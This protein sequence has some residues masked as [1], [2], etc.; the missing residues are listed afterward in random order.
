MHAHVI[1]TERDLDSA[2]S[3]NSNAIVRSRRQCLR[4]G[5]TYWDNLIFEFGPQ[6]FIYADGNAVVGFASERDAA[7]Q[8][9]IEFADKYKT[10]PKPMGGCFQL[11]K[12]QDDRIDTAA[13][14]LEPNTIV[15]DETLKL[16]YG[17]GFAEWHH[18]YAGQL[19]ERACGLSILQGGPGTGK[20]SYLRHL[21]GVL[22]DSHRFYYVQPTH[23]CVLAKP[24]FVQFWVSERRRYSD[25]RFVVILEDAE[26][27]IMRR[28][29]D[30]SAH[31]SAILNLSDGLLGD[32]VRLH[33]ICTMNCAATDV[34]PAL[35]RPG[36]LLSHRVFDRLDKSTAERLAKHLGKALP[37][38]SDYSLAEIFAEDASDKTSRPRMGFSA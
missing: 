23:M 15:S 1:C 36:R 34:D 32:F 18:S 19:P 4:D 28:G 14:T 16:H 27:A 20:T 13:V 2:V 10:P 9:A 8:M 17:N 24:E 31:V 5:K 33:V 7:A 29:S 3:E 37:T 35:L 38:A 30:N 11:I 25:R 22:K 12:I 6:R 21:M 26:E